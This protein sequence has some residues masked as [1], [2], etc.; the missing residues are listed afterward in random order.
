MAISVRRWHQS[1]E[2]VSSIVS[3]SQF[4]RRSLR[5][6]WIHLRIETTL[7][8]QTEYDSRTGFCPRR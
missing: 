7:P 5:T 4:T 6:R 1:C 8:L 2:P 3:C